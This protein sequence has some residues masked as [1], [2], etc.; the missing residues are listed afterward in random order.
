MPQ[1][2]RQ[3][4][5][6]AAWSLVDKILRSLAREVTQ[7]D[8]HFALVYVPSRME[9]SDR[10]DGVAPNPDLAPTLRVTQ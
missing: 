4:K 2:R 7:R 9:V 10:D 1:R 3:P 8:A 5:I 6:E